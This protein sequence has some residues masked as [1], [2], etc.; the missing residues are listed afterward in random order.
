VFIGAASSDYA[1]LIQ[2]KASDA[3]LSAY[4]GTGNANSV[5]AG[6]LAYFLGVHGPTLAIDTACSS[7]LVALHTA[8]NSLRSGESDCAIAG[9]VNVMLSPQMTVHFCQNGMLSP[10]ARCKTFD[11]AADGYTRAEGGGVVVLKRLADE[12][13]NG[14]RVLAVA[15]LSRQSRWLQ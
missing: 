2:T 14:D 6:R 15:Q 13:L 12:Q 4:W 10:D 8:C 7:A 3:D 9:G 1:N 11:A 5:L